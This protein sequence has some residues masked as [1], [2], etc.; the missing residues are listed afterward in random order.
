MEKGIKMKKIVMILL[1]ILAFSTMLMASIPV[2]SASNING[3]IYYINPVTGTTSQYLYI[4]DVSATLL[5]NVGEEIGSGTRP[6]VHSHF[7]I[8]FIMD[9]GK[10]LQDGRS[11]TITFT[12]QWGH[13]HTKTVT[14]DFGNPHTRAD[15]YFTYVDPI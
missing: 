4:V 5:N 7:A 6:T 12:D 1:A 15:F 9:P 2:G 14:H 13:V 3:T 11:F 8:D 10:S